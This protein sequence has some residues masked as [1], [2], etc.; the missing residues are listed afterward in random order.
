MTPKPTEAAPGPDRR[1]QIV[2]AAMASFARRGFHQTTMQDISE[3]A[4]ISVGLIYRY[5]ESK[6]QVIA[7]MAEEHL[8]DL[9]RKIA[10][11]RSEPTLLEAIERVVWCDHE[12]DLA[13]SFVV[14]LFAEAGRNAHVRALVHQVHGAVI[15]G[16]TDLIA[17]SPEAARLAPGLSPPDAA[18]MIVHAIH[19][20]L[21][22]EIVQAEPRTADAIQHVRSAT[23]RRLWT[24]LFSAPVV[25]ADR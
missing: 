1:L 2:D 19:G 5:F 15:R 18:E 12:A 11:A 20:Q 9:N 25:P 6:D 17:A 14:D 10:E 7:A 16:V 22:D 8:A 3:A 24:L 23:L 21:F 13:A 4:G